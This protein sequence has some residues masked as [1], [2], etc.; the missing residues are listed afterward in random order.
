MNKENLKNMIKKVDELIDSIANIKKEFTGGEPMAEELKEEKVVASAE[1]PTAEVKE[2]VKEE[3][4]ATE[5]VK[6]EA[7][8]E[9]KEEVTEETKAEEKTEEVKTEASEEVKEEVVAEV[10]TEEVKT[11]AS[12]EEDAKAIEAAEKEKSEAAEKELL[13]VL[14]S[15]IAK[16]L[17][18]KAELTEEEI[19]LA[20]DKTILDLVRLANTLTKQVAEIELAKKETE[21]TA[22][23]EKRFSELAEAGLALSGSKAEAQKAKVGKMSDEAFASYRDELSDL[24]STKSD[25]EKAKESVGDKAISST[26]EPKDLRT[27]FSLL[28]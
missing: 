21:Q 13:S 22:L 16:E 20:S 25:I 1:E 26:L 7:T 23:A 27:K 11:E 14:N 10:V 24:I 18:V 9:V 28:K 19:A 4:V 3:A 8:E 15:A 2:E 12:I 6:A 5:E 17:L